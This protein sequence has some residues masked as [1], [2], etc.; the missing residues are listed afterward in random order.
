M[1]DAAVTE[2][3]MVVDVLPITVAVALPT[4]V[5]PPT[6]A[7]VVQRTLV[8]PQ[9]LAVVVL[10]TLV[11]DVQ[12]LVA[13]PSTAVRSAASP[14]AAVRSA[15]SPSAAKRSAAKRSAVRYAAAVTA[16]AIAD[17]PHLRVVLPCPDVDA[18]NHLMSVT[19][20]HQRIS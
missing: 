4:M 19:Y 9:T 14:S 7:V 1:N 10:R 5:V 6:L 15:T 18:V 8:A 13:S 11:V 17:V 3:M 20:S 12:L 2:G 16:V